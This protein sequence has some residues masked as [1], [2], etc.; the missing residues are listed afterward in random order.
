MHWKGFGGGPEVWEQVDAFFERL[1][2]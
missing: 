2:R 1:R